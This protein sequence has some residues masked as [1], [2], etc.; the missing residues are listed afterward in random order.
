MENTTDF[1]VSIGQYHPC[2]ALREGTESHDPLWLENLDEPAQMIIA[3]CID[4]VAFARWQFV[5]RSIATGFLHEDERTIVGDEMAPEECLWFPP[6]L[7]DRT[8][9]TCTTDLAASTGKS[10]H[11][12]LGVFV[13]GSVD[14]FF[15]LQPVPNDTDLDRKSVV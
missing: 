15:D 12:S 2:P 6:V 4:S 9:E 7:S 10:V 11:R 13:G 8:P 1:Q 3:C 5:G 14:S